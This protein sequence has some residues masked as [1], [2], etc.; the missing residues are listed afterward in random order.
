MHGQ[1][2]LPVEEWLRET[3]KDDE[4]RFA[5]FNDA[6]TSRDLLDFGCGAGGFLIRAK[7]R[8]RSAIGIE[9]EARLQQHFKANGLEVVQRIEELPTSRRFDVITA[10]HVIEHLQDPAATLSELAARCRLDGKILVEIPSS[11]DALLTLYENTPFTEFTYWS[12][13]LYLFNATNLTNLAKKAGLRLDYVKHVQ[14]HPISNHLY[15]LAKGKPGGHKTW[16]F[17]DS[18]DLDRAYEASLA[19]IGKTD[20][21][22]ACFSPKQ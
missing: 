14:R 9:L 11:S 15:W 3:V 18:K 22:I 2:P 13:H 16:N 10:F 17:L 5:F 8:V 1:E 20:T 4:R 6:I 19:A 21:I 7:E 12:C